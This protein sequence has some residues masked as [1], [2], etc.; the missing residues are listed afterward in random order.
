MGPKS[1]FALQAP[2]EFTVASW[3]F[4]KVLGAIYLIAFLSFGVQAIGLIGSNGVLP[5]G[6]YMNAAAT[7]LGTARFRLVPSLFW[8]SSSDTMIRL[9]WIAGAIASLAIIAGFVQRIALAA[10][11]VLYLSIVTGGQTFM[12]FQWDLLLL[13]AGFIAIF[14]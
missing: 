11:F 2:R 8:L 6:S 7:Q 12:T 14:L 10:A 13:E 1:W 4:L 5:L 9:V 3:I